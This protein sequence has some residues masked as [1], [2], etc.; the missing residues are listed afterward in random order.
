HGVAVAFDRQLDD[1]L[2]VEVDRV[3]GERSARGV[4]DSLVDRQDGTGAGAC[5]RP[6]SAGRMAR[7]PVLPRRPW[8]NM[9]GRPRSTRVGRSESFHTLSTKSGPGRCSCEAGTVALLWVSRSVAS[10]PRTSS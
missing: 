6:R 5:P 10:A 9:V 7:E 8:R 3:G 2:A 1:L 4:L